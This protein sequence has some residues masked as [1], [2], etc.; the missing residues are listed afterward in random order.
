MKRGGFTLI[1]L[2]IVAFSQGQI[3]DNWTFGYHSGLNFATTP[4]SIFSDSIS[5]RRCNPNPTDFT[6]PCIASNTISDCNGKLLFYTNGYIVWNKNHIA[7]PNSCINDTFPGG[8]PANLKTKILKF[9]GNDSLYYIFYTTK[10]KGL[11]YAVVNINADNGNG[12]I[13]SSHNFINNFYTGPSTI[14]VCPPELIKH[15]NDTNYWLVCKPTDNEVYSYLITSQG[16]NLTPVISLAPGANSRRFPIKASLSGDFL[17]YSSDSAGSLMTYNCTV[18]NFNR[19]IGTV[20]N[21]KIIYSKSNHPTKE[22]LLMDIEFSPNDSLIYIITFENDSS[23]TGRFRIFQIKRYLTNPT[24]S[25]VQLISIQINMWAIQIAPDGKIYISNALKTFISC[26]TR[27]DEIGTACNYI[28]NYIDFSPNIITGGFPNVYFPLKRLKFNATAYT[29]TNCMNDSIRLYAQGDTTFLNYRWYFYNSSNILT[30]SSDLKNPVLWLNSG[31]YKVKLRAKN[32]QC[33]SYTWWTDDIYVS[34]Q[35]IISAT[36]DSS[37]IS[38]ARQTLF[39]HYDIKNADSLFIDWGDGISS[40][41]Y[42]TPGINSIN[43]D[44]L[45]SNKVY[46]IKLKATNGKCIDSLIL[47]DTVRL[48]AKPKANFFANNSTKTFPIKGCSPLLINLTDSSQNADSVWYCIRNS[49]ST[50]NHLSGINYLLNDTGWFNI[51]QYNS[52]HDGCIDSFSINNGVYASPRAKATVTK[53]SVYNRC[54]QNNLRLKIISSFNDSLVVSWGDGNSNIFVGNINGNITYFPNHNYTIAGNYTISIRSRNTFCDTIV[55][56]THLVR[57]P[58]QMKTS[59]DTT[60]CIGTITNI[61]SIASGADSVYSYILTGQSLTLLN[62]SGTFL[63]QPTTATSYRIGA[64]NACAADTLWKSITISLLKPLKL[65]LNTTDT[66]LCKGA[67]F[68]L[69]AAG[70]GGNGKYTYTLKK[71]G[72]IIQSNSTGNFNLTIAS[73]N[74]I[75]SVV[76]SDNCTINNDSIE[77][78]I[79]VYY[80]LQFTQLQPDIFLCEGITTTLKALTNKGSGQVQYTWTE[81]GGNILS[82]TDSLEKIYSSSTQIILKASDNCITILDTF[83]VYTFASTNN[84]NIQTDVASGCAPLAV[85]FETAPLT[86]SNSLQCEAYWDFGDGSTLVQDFNSSS[87][88][89][90]A[91][92]TYAFA[93]IYTVQLRLKFKASSIACYTL[94]TTIEALLVP[95]IKL[96]VTPLKITLPKTECTASVTATNTDSVVIDWDDGNTD[97]FT[98]N[99]N[100]ISQLHNYSDTGQF[101][102]KAT[103][104]NK[105]TCFTEVK[106]LVIHTDTFHCFIPNAFTPNKDDINDAFKPVVNFC[107]SYELIIYNRWGEQ[108]YQLIFNSNSPIVSGWSGENNPPDLYLYRFFAIDGDFQRHYLTGT[109]LLL[110]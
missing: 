11:R 84:L 26:I 78:K 59:N 92:H 107:K 86:F 24:A 41:L 82:V 45:D 81:L 40:S 75:Y 101:L 42:N 25:I 76:L 70:S 79:Q 71:N 93:G 89:L 109:V 63:V 8:L 49:T 106:T 57:P 51:I 73:I 53:D 43:H 80:I 105:N 91:K 104:Y 33:D 48:Q 65:S 90:K 102:V 34:H 13:I 31:A 55:Y 66:I 38:C 18:C 98:S 12:D 44:Y 100:S 35:P 16:I 36:I 30:D 6:S 17:F 99:F 108:V 74:E 64:I 103:A 61:W 60:L 19:N 5:M 9:I 29:N 46:S 50:Y 23:P 7:M 88:I 4:P 87:P 83:W 3:A 72:N 54:F 56:L 62:N 96:N 67:S 28:Y 39:F 47:M 52:T 94:T 22:V 10:Q 95:Q 1:L 32:P 27:P 110:K 68:N 21:K 77:C 14:L 58:L 15:A 85:N 20:S 2:A 37:K 69:I 97:Y